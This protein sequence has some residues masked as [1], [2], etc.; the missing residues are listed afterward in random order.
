MFYLTPIIDEI[1]AL[2][3]HYT[4]INYFQ[5]R[6]FDINNSFNELDALF[7]KMMQKHNFPIA[8]NYPVTNI[9]FNTDG[10]LELELGVTG[11]GKDEL[12]VSCIDDN[13]IVIKGTK[14]KENDN[15]N[16]QKKYIYKKLVCKDFEVKYKISEKY[17]I[18]N[19][20]IQLSNG[21]LTIKFNLKPEAQQ[22]KKILNINSI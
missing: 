1:F 7:E 6:P 11:F 22:K 21:L 13:I 4:C 9:L 15:K 18:E 19:P 16:E 2:L 8:P 10:T 20:M 12:E 3:D 17:D 5:S 14:K